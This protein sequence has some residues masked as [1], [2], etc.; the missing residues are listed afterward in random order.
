MKKLAFYIALILLF[1]I[2]CNYK[3][4]INKQAQL[5][6]TI[7]PK[8]NI[9]VHKE[10][11]KHGNLIS[12]D[13]TYSYFYS[14]IKNDSL[15]ESEIFQDFKL[16]FNNQFK[17]FDSLFINDFFND[18]PLWNKDF[19]TDK[20][21]QNNFENHQKRIEKIFKRMDSLKNS[22]YTKQNEI[23]KNNKIEH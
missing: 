9:K 15:L 3:A 12:I 16:N 13:S 4:K 5:I 21:F 7:K 17:S 10:Y 23:L 2:S 18:R 22:F 6:D 1:S 14:N 19:Y 20:F 8:V 11:D